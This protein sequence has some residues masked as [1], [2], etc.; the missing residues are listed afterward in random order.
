MA[1]YL[2]KETAYLIFSYLLDHRSTLP[3]TINTFLAES[4][5]LT[6]LRG[7]KNKGGNV[8][9]LTL[10]CK[11]RLKGKSLVNI[12]SEHTIMVDKIQLRAKKMGMVDSCTR[13]IEKVLDFVLNI[14][15]QDLTSNDQSKDKFTVYSESKA[16]RSDSNIGLKIKSPKSTSHQSNPLHPSTKACSSALHGGLISGKV[17]LPCNVGTPLHFNKRK[18]EAEVTLA[19]PISREKFKKIAPKVRDESGVGAVTMVSVNLPSNKSNIKPVPNKTYIS[20][21]FHRRG[22]LKTNPPP[23]RSKPTDHFYAIQN[24]PSNNNFENDPLED[25]LPLD[26][27]IPVIKVEPTDF[28]SMGLEDTILSDNPFSCEKNYETCPSSEINNNND[29][30]EKGVHPMAF[31]T[32]FLTNPDNSTIPIRAPNSII[33]I[34]SDTLALL[35]DVKVE[36]ETKDFSHTNTQGKALDEAINNHENSEDISTASEEMS[37]QSSGTMSLLPKSED[38]GAKKQPKKPGNKRRKSRCMNCSGCSRFDCGICKYCLDKTKFGGAN[39][40]R[41]ACVR[42]KCSGI[43]GPSSKCKTCSGCIRPDCGKCKNCLDKI[44][45]GGANILRKACVRKKCT[46]STKPRRRRVACRGCSGCRRLDCGECKNC[47]DKPKYGGANTLRRVCVR[48]ICSGIS[49]P[50]R[51]CKTCSAVL[52]KDLNPSELSEDSSSEDNHEATYE[53]ISSRGRKMKCKALFK[54]FFDD[55]NLEIE[56]MNI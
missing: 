14:E 44:K 16:T 8:A 25:P 31:C 49:G 18:P 30:I 40:L 15:H 35:C 27:A 12:L 19:V 24:N 9:Q 3:I 37:Q 33:P 7:L 5:F 20:K 6:E 56:E 13:P 36:P 47:L 26:R 41:K 32:S 53:Y 29:K 34:N 39:I 52:I 46:G 23:T 4:D 43:T 48:K 38:K 45:F 28:V 42:T 54:G 55:T 21:S 22:L 10:N 17:S 2:P 50:S 11:V 51:K 1:M